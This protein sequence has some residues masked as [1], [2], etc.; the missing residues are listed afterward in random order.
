MPI[1]YNF[2]ELQPPGALR[3]CSDLKG[4]DFTSFEDP[5]V[6]DSVSPSSYVGIPAMS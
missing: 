3:A 1:V 4:I 5:Q 2:W 6:S